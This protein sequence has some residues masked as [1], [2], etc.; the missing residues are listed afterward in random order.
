MLTTTT[1]TSASRNTRDAVD[2]RSIVDSVGIYN[3][4]TVVT[5]YNCG[6]DA[7]QLRLCIPVKHA[8]PA[9]DAD[10]PTDATNCTGAVRIT[11]DNVSLSSSNSV[12]TPRITN[13]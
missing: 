5:I 3:N 11:G 8:T 10:N 1:I 7:C 9:V 12:A 4:I 6:H 13:T 2:L